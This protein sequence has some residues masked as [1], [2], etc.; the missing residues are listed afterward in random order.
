MAEKTDTV[1]YGSDETT[2]ILEEVE[3]FA[4]LLFTFD[5]VVVLTEASSTVA[6]SEQ[7]KTAYVRGQ[8]KRV[9][10]LRQSLLRMAE[11]G[12]Q[13]AMNAAI[14]LAEIASTSYD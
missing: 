1:E 14:K 9:A 2:E 4:N 13:P 11:Q 6:D 3:S 10:Q 8:L 5:E 7:F 12:S